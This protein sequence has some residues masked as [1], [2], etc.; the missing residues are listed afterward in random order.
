LYWCNYDDVIA[1]YETAR[2]RALREGR[3]LRFQGWD[4]TGKVTVRYQ[5]G[6]PVAEVQGVDRR[7]QID[8]VDP[9]AWSSP[10][11]SERRKLARTRVR[12]RV[13]S[14]GREPVWLELPVVL[15]R[16]L[17]ENAS[18]RSASA[19]CEKVGNR[20]RWRLLVTVAQPD[21]ESRQGPAVAVDL[22]WRLLP[23]GLRVAYWEDE[24]GDHGQLL[25]EPAVLWQFSKLND[26]RSIQDQHLRAALNVVGPWLKEHELN[27]GMD[28]SHVGEWRKPW[29][30]LRLYRAWKD[31]RVEGDASAFG[32]LVVWK[33]RHDHLHEWEANLRDQVIRHRKE[34]Y[35][36]FVASL[37]STHGRVFLEDLQIRSMARKELPE[38]NLHSYSGSMRV[39]AA[40]SL[41]GRMFD[42]HGDCVRVSAQH[43]TRHCSWCGHA[44]EWDAAENIMHRCEGCGR[45]FD[46]DQNA[47]RN[48]LRRGLGDAVPCQEVAA[49]ATV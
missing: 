40:V 47:A 25:L 14:D 12:I 27:A 21:H 35:R 8:P 10:H 7:L 22:G 41:L 28:L 11:R 44:K 31:H 1:N 24:L 18:I 3:E 32:A 9:L 30:L 13:G 36:R 29:R 17:P 49:L 34:I 38:E 43:T 48:V 26:L 2:K 19:I 37:L 15:H 5:Q 45:L 33:E 16:A 4:G 46:Q 6:L 39:V 20:E 23:D 42:E